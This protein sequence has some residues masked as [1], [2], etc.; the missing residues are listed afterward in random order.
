MYAA[1]QERNGGASA[2]AT[3]RQW[4]PQKGGVA[5]VMTGLAMATGGRVP[6]VISA[7]RAAYRELTS[8]KPSGYGDLTRGETNQIQDVVNAAERPLDVVGSAAAG[9]RRNPGSDLPMGKGPGT[10]SDID[11]VASP[12]SLKEISPYQDKLPSLDPQT[13]VNPGSGNAYQGPVV[14]FR[15]NEK[16]E[17]LVPK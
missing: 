5:A 14:R 17:V 4:Y 13:G 9:A 11:Y 3:L 2:N 15:P 16:P 8:G 1:E 12:S 6:G 10:K 7:W